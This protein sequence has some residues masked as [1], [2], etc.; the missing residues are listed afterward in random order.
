MLPSR[1]NS[2]WSLNP[3]LV[4][5]LPANLVSIVTIMNVGESADVKKLSP[6]MSPQ[7]LLKW[8]QDRKTWNKFNGYFEFHI[9]FFLTFC[10]QLKSNCHR[11]KKKIN[12]HFLSFNQKICTSCG[13]LK[14]QTILWSFMFCVFIHYNIS[15]LL[16]YYSTNHE[17]G[18]VSC[19]ISGLLKLQT[20]LYEFYVLCVY[21]L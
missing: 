18:F 4:T 14:L 7:R 2:K 13:L 6:T 3:L 12:L 17:V 19:T 20:I 8:S 9:H 15:R 1:S 11:V 21:I 5:L 16:W 10:K